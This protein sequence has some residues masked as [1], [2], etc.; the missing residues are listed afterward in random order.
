MMR[1][2]YRHAS[3][4]LPP[5]ALTTENVEGLFATEDVMQRFGRTLVGIGETPTDFYR[6]VHT[7]DDRSFVVFASQTIIDRIIKDIDVTRRS[8][9]MD[10]TFKICP[11]GDYLQLLVIHIEHIHLVKLI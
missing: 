3:S 9:L 8:Y 5:S 11:Y 7:A 6:G 2:A 1:T 4:A 10:G